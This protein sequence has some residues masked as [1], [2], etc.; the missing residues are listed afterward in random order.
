MMTASNAVS[1]WPAARAVPSPI[2][3]V[4]QFHPSCASGDGIT[5]GMFLTQKI[6]RRL[7]YQSEIYCENIPPELEPVVHHASKLE[8]RPGDL[9]LFHHSLGYRNL[10]WLKRVAARKVLVYHNITP[11]FLLPEGDLRELSRLGRNQLQEVRSLFEASIGDSE[12]NAQELEALGYRDVRVLPLL[13]DLDR[14]GAHPPN[15]GLVNS[16]Q[17][18]V[19]ILFVGRI[20]ENKRQADL[21]DCFNLYHRHFEPRARLHL[22]GSTTS[23]GYL[24][25]IRRKVSELDLE[26]V[27]SLPGKVSE[28]DLAAY[29]QVAD[30]YLSLSE[31]EGFG[32]PLIEAMA[33]GVPVVAHASTSIPWTVGSGGLLLQTRDP[34]YVAAT[35][36]MVVLNPG[37][38]RAMRRGA[39]RSLGRFESA[40]LEHDLSR[41]LHE[42]S[43]RGVEETP[44]LPSMTG[45]W[46]VEGPFDSSYSL[47]IV[48]RNVAIALSEAGLPAGL[49]STEGG[50]D[51]PPDAAF[52]A[53]NPTIGELVETGRDALHQDVTLRFCYP[54]RTEGMQGLVRAIHSYGWEETGFPQRYVNW[55]NQRLDLVTVLST[56]VK[57][58]L[59]DAGVKV[60]VAVVGAGTD[61]LPGSVDEQ[62]RPGQG[63]F[64]FLHV[65]SCFPR[66]AP[67]V[68]LEA[69]G[70]AFT[71]D[72][73][74]VLLI[75]TFPNPHHSIEAD[76]LAFR[77]KFPRAAPV[78]IVNADVDDEALSRMYQAA[79]AYVGAGRGEGYGL[80]LAEAMR[81]GLPVITTAWGG[82]TDFCDESTAWMVDY[83]FD[84]SRSHLVEGVSLWAEPDVQHLA[85]RLREVFSATAQQRQQRTGLARARITA[86]SSWARVAQRTKQAVEALSSLPQ[87]SP[88]LQ[89]GW[90]TT[91]NSRCGIAEYSRYLVDGLHAQPGPIFAN[92][93]S[94]LIGPDAERVVRC[95]DSG[96]PHESLDEVFEQIRTRGLDALVIQYNFG[97]FTLPVLAR[98][99]TRLRQHGIAVYCVFHSTAEFMR[100]NER[101]SLGDIKEA[102][103]GATRLFVHSVPDL[104]R[105]K[106]Y[107]LAANASIFL[108][109]VRQPRKPSPSSRNVIGS[110][111]FLLPGKGLPQLIEA[112]SLL[113]KNDAS[114]RLKLV[115]ALYPAPVSNEELARC[116]AQIKALGL[117][118]RVELETRFLS[119]DAALDQLADVSLLVFPYQETRESS[120]AA[121]RLGIASGRP[122]AVTPLTVFED[123]GEA[124]FRL[125]GVTPPELAEGIAQLLGQADLETKSTEMTERWCAPRRWSAVATKLLNVIESCAVNAEFDRVLKQHHG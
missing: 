72:D 48:N 28:E 60:P 13:V 120:S 109:G 51:F 9:L 102:L 75:K 111:G 11:D 80:P 100:G 6:L 77:A 76:V 49:L 94:D 105:L 108:H 10:H 12:E 43:G 101:V 78:E 47:A 93:T 74:A 32:M 63:P 39:R 5:N 7:G 69:W 25:A 62:R 84:Y 87:F 30:V 41:L 45:S 4:H 35:L 91:W 50:G 53:A 124:V 20:A 16:L 103:G 15:R 14:S 99:I 27:V 46:R 3:A 44:V 2:G 56:T 113:A 122:V 118:G 121:V 88:D 110:F 66:K 17:D 106:S 19:N 24:S 82:Q 67:D 97:F 95:W 81:H 92:R 71:S 89:V 79:D 52:V 1:G 73:A 23:R 18:S 29:Y 86:E 34:E 85:T 90:L 65:S 26:S 36:D 112:F 33:M 22:V 8:D 55:F 107:G 40:A 38:R 42:L 64:R 83:T 58:V 116:E 114:L 37:L 117:E 31:H 123:V 115:N 61:H 59:M 21:L 54:P 68:L 57:K 104:N 70:R 98:F 96:A 125:P 119:E